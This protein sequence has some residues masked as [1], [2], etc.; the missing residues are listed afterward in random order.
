MGISSGVRLAPMIP[1]TWATVSTSP[2]FMPPLRMR[3]KVSSFTRTRAAAT[4]VRR[5]TG[6]SPT[7]TIFARPCSLKWVKSFISSSPFAFDSPF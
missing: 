6:F 7:S 1:A 2:F 5:V 3:A 4:A